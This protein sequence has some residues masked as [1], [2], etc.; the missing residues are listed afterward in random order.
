MILVVRYVLHPDELQHSDGRIKHDQLC[1][2]LYPYHPSAIE[3]RM[4]V[5]DKHIVKLGD[6][7]TAFNVIKSERQRVEL[8]KSDFGLLSHVSTDDALREISSKPSALPSEQ[9][10]S[11]A[12]AANGH[13]NGKMANGSTSAAHSA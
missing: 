9:K 1:P 3:Q 5:A 10:A 11:P 4:I 2:D 6:T 8:L 13:A 7:Q 12:P